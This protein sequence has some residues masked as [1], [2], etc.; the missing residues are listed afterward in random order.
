MKI[1]YLSHSCIHIESGEHKILIDPFLTGNGRAPIAAHEVECD[2]ILVT[3]GH[4]DHVGDTADIA[5]RTGA[6]IVANYEIATHFERQGLTTHG[7]YHGG[8]WDFPFGRVKM[9]VAHHG[10]GFSGGDAPFVYMGNPAGFVLTIEGKNIYHAGDTCA[11]IDMQ[12]I[13]RL[14]PLDL[15]FLPIGDNFTMGLEEASVALEF[16]RPKKAVPIHFDTWE[17]IK[18]DP[19]EFVLR[20]ADANVE[21]IALAPGQSIEL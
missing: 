13:A 17:V 8:K 16:L 12:L 14:S 2:Y 1:T 5:R 20:C 11:F 6:T 7:M 9:V 21:G 4:D 3:H 15:A 10:S 19:G 18:S